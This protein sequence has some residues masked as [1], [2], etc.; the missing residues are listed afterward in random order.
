MSVCVH[1]RARERGTSLL[2]L[3]ITST[4]S[5]MCGCVTTVQHSGKNV[6]VSAWTTNG[7]ARSGWAC[8]VFA[9]CVS[10]YTL[11]LICFMEYLTKLQ[12]KKEKLHLDFN[13]QTNHV[14]S[15][16]NTVAWWTWLC[17]IDHTT[18]FTSGP[19]NT[20]TVAMQTMITE[21]WYQILNG[22][23]RNSVYNLS[24]YQWELL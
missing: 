10:C 20:S 15:G 6:C 3:Y 13:P 16:S 8:C 23:Y 5:F 4:D 14:I 12:K 11:C 19:Q 7:R 21:I 2:W 17:K 24:V 1:A 18:T 9:P 22:F